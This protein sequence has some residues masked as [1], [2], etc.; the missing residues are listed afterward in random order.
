MSMA[1]KKEPLRNE[2]KKS[3]PPKQNLHSAIYE[4]DPTSPEALHF[5]VL[6]SI[7][8]LLYLGYCALSLATCIGR[9]VDLESLL[10]LGG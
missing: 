3:C 4:L 2:S 10:V 9:A 7:H 6:E 5:P 8:I 1:G